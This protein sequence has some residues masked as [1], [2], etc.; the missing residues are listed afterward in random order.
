MNG[1][2][3]WWAGALA[4][5]ICAFCWTD[6][7]ATQIDWNTWTSATQGTISPDGVTVNFSIA[8][9][10]SADNLVSNYP[11][12]TPTTTFA[13]GSTVSNAPTASN[14]IIQ[15]TGG[16]SN[17]N[18]ITFSSPVVDP[19]MA[20]WSLGAGGTAAT[21][22]FSDATPLF[23][24]GGPS[25]EYGGSAIS[26]SG[27]VVS[28][29]EGNGTVMFKGTF[30]SISWTNPQYEGWYGFDVGIAGLARP[31][32]VPEPAPWGLFALGLIGIALAQLKRKA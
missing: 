12:Y 26:V 18:T 31:S 4:I 1:R 16:N 11:S 8:G 14:G 29:S 5:G 7:Q 24:A 2:I 32:P 30:D 23:V 15:L 3:R 6:A 9:S 17:L 19:V 10:G 21:F 13:D 22:V 20:I 28:G 27:N 25:A